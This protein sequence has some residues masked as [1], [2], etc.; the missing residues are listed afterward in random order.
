MASLGGDP[1]AV[2][3]LP[4]HYVAA[5]TALGYAATIDTA[6]GVTADTCHVVGSDQLSRQHLYVALTR[7]RRENH[8][9]FSI[10]ESDPHRIL[11]RK[12]SIRRP[13]WTS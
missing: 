4:A 3:R 12:P 1:D 13:R 7:G 11:T 9:Y 5:H 10:A 2:V 6:K 8:L